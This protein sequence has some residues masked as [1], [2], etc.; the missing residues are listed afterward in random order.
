MVIDEFIQT[1]AQ[2]ELIKI[3]ARRAAGEDPFALDEHGSPKRGVP[4]AGSPRSSAKGSPKASSPTS[5]SIN[6]TNKGPR[7]L[8]AADIEKLKSSGAAREI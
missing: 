3:Q 2:Q 6:G 5:S 7:T 8:T 4:A 1:Y